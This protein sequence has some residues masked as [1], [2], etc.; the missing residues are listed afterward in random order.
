MNGSIS[1][2]RNYLHQGLLHLLYP[3]KQLFDDWNATSTAIKLYLQITE[4]ARRVFSAI[5]LQKLNAPLKNFTE[6]S[7]VRNFFRQ[8][9]KIISGKAGRGFDEDIGEKTF[10]VYKITSNLARLVRNICSTVKWLTKNSII[11]EEI[12]KKAAYIPIF[13]K[14]FRIVQ[15]LKITSSFVSSLFSLIYN[16]TELAKGLKKNGLFHR[17]YIFSLAHDVT[18]LAS[19]VLSCIPG[20]SSIYATSI[21]ATGSV[22][23][24]GR[25]TKKQLD[26]R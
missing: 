14:S 18:K 4:I 23:A 22:I 2:D 9:H 26:N 5:S 15:S 13:K 3:C 1:F 16:T 20:V 7:G 8:T 25:F 12:S 17:T 10:N 6:F 19:L 24:L 11:S 21:M